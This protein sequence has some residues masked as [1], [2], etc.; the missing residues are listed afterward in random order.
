MKKMMDSIP[1]SPRI[2]LYEGMTISDLPKPWTIRE[3]GFISDS[4]INSGPAREWVER[5]QRGSHQRE[6]TKRDIKKQLDELNHPV[7]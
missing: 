7:V 6:A 1:F 3:M 5:W 2:P 4:L